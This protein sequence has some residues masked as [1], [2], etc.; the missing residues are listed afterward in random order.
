MSHKPVTIPTSLFIFRDIKAKGFW[1]SRWIEEHNVQE[2]TKMLSV[3]FDMIKKQTLKLWVETW[4][5]KYLFDAIKKNGQPYRERKIILL[6]N[7]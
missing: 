1:L 3:L 4:E 7:Q 6:L 5:F 2:K